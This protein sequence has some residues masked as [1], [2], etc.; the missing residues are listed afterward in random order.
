M[1]EPGDASAADAA[2]AAELKLGREHGWYR[3]DCHVHS[4][5]SGG[6]LAPE[7]LVVD[8]RAVGLDFVVATEHNTAEGREV[9]ARFGGGDL[10]VLFGEEMVTRTGHWLAIGLDTRQ[11]VDWDYGVRDG[12]VERQLDEVHRAGGLSVAAH[13]HAPYPGGGFMYA[14]QGFDLVEVWN[15]EWFSD[16]W[17]QANNE[18]ALAEWGRSLASEVCQGRW[19]PAIGNSDTHIEGQIGI[20]HTVVAAAELTPA[21][22]LDGIRAGRSWI[23]ES[24]AVELALTVTAAD[25]RSAGIGEQLDTQGESAVVRVLVR[26][27]PGGTVTLYT[28]KGAAHRVS[29]P[30]TGSDDVR[31]ETSAAEAGFVRVEVRHPGGRMAALSNPIILS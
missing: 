14:Y 31:W 10:M 19:R 4:L 9:W 20:P 21:A 22:I 6:E 28:E 16:L 30:A 24:A 3:G 1:T 7:R 13:P 8:A 25:G 2:D 18:A 26:G 15:G 11:V 29:L 27:V 12:L 17:W 5:Y 23:A